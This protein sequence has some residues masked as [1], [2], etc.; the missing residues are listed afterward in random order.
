MRFQL[1]VLFRAARR[2]RRVEWCKQA[3]PADRQLEACSREGYQR[4][5]AGAHFRSHDVV[6]ARLDGESVFETCGLGPG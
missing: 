3:W 4:I 2:R 6:A 5:R 1:G